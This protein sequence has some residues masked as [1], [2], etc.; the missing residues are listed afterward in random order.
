MNINIEKNRRLASR[1]YDHAA[2][3][4]VVDAFAE[5]YLMRGLHASLM[6]RVHHHCEM[7]GVQWP[8]VIAAARRRMGVTL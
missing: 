8:D 7:L 2:G 1:T 5:E 6:P 3:R 4:R